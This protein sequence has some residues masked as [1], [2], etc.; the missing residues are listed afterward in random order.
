MHIFR[1]F[2][3]NR[4]S[5]YS[6][7]TDF[8]LFNSRYNTIMTD[9][10]RERENRMVFVWRSDDHGRFFLPANSLDSFPPG[11]RFSNNLSVEYVHVNHPINRIAE[12][13]PDD[14]WDGLHEAHLLY[15][16]TYI[17]SILFVGMIFDDCLFEKYLFCS[18]DKR[19]SRLSTVRYS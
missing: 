15:D 10:E 16:L 9:R 8:V 14:D 19:Y 3:W 18:R 5:I 4:K 11:Q 2:T 17:Y 12:K 6:K 7:K 13:K 1:M